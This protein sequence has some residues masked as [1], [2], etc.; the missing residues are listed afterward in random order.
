MVDVSS[1]YTVSMDGN[2]PGSLGWVGGVMW[3]M[4]LTC[5]GAGDEIN[6]HIFHPNNALP[7]FI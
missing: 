6:N 1:I 7:T 5:T 4:A 2:A 3:Q